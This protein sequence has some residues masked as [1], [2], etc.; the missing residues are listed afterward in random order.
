MVPWTIALGLIFCRNA[1]PDTD[2]FPA[3]RHVVSDLHGGSFNI[4]RNEEIRNAPNSTLEQLGS[5]LVTQTAN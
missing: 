2:G 3:V 1:N 5:S 4:R